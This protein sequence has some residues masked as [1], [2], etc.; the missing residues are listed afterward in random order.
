MNKKELAYVGW[1]DKEKN[2]IYLNKEN[3]INETYK[4]RPK[5][6]EEIEKKAP[7]WLIVWGVETSDELYSKIISLDKEK[8][9][10]GLMFLMFQTILVIDSPLV[11]PGPESQIRLRECFEK[12]KESDIN[13]FNKFDDNL[14]KKIGLEK[15]KWWKF[16]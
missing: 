4:K 6:F 3:L 9:K 8:E 5:N 14:L 1:Y 11:N 10:I 16:W 15:N 2:K 13:L 12:I 7:N